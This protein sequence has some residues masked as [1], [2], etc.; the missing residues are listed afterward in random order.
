MQEIESYQ[1]FQISEVVIDTYS[2]AE[3]GGNQKSHPST[4]PCQTTC[5]L[6][7]FKNVIR[8]Q[9]IDLFANV[10]GFFAEDQKV[11]ICQRLIEESNPESFVN[12]KRDG[13]I[14]EQVVIGDI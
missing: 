7:P 13:C 5:P 2:H 1:F 9:G 12:G 4:R 3:F 14:R 8:V 11:T 10:E 6:C